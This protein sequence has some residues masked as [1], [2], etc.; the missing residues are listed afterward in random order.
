MKYAF[1]LGR[2]PGLSVAEILTQLKT[3]GIGHDPKAAVYCP[4]VMLVETDK[5]LDFAFFH[6]LG[7]S[8]KMAEVVL[9]TSD[10]EQGIIVALEGLARESLDFGLSA[11]SIDPEAGPTFRN[12][13]NGLKPLALTVK[14]KLRDGGRSVRVVMPEGSELSS[15]Q[16]D[17]NNLIK[18]GAELLL[19]VGAKNITICRTIA[20]QAF[21]AFSS[22]DFGRPK[23]DATSGML[24]PKLARMMVNLAGAPKNQTLLDPFC[25][26][27]TV[28]TE[29]LALGYR[30]LMG[31]DI[32]PKAV[33][34]TKA[35][36]AW[37]LEKLRAPTATEVKIF[38]LDVKDLLN[39]MEKKSIG[40]VVSEPFLGPPLRGGESDQKKHFIF[41]EL[42]GLYRRAFTAFSHVLKPGASVVFVF[43][44]IDNKHVNLLR[45][46]ETLGFK[47]EALLPT[48]AATA[49]GLKTPVGL[50]YKRPDQLVGRDIFRF[51]FKGDSA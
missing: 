9:E 3:Q 16:V 39:K 32:S 51:R 19:L 45:D 15:V 14:K 29:A 1:I 10:L 26:S 38:E 13:V 2:E 25:G 34:D 44:V 33:A 27:G 8:I 46:L 31:S 37:M 30:N 48:H 50:M 24:P 21:E 49:L 11:Y 42:M 22:R 17:K 28:L 40:A 47:A 4:D 41:L 35:N 23:A 5:E 12:L 20:V 7:G 43:P 36:V 18:K 6:A